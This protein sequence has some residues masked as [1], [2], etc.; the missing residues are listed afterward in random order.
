MASSLR[1]RNA[2]VY[3]VRKQN[4]NILIHVVLFTCILNVSIVLLTVNNFVNSNGF[5]IVNNKNKN[6]SL[7][8][9]LHRYDH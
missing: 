8:T 5:K 7:W 2:S 4:Q 6:V 3:V 1:R 9:L